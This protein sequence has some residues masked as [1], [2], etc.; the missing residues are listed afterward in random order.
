MKEIFKPTKE[1]LAAITAPLEPA[2]VLAGAGTGKTSVMAQRVLWLITEAKIEPSEI[3]GLTFTNKASQELRSRIRTTITKL[4]SNKL[5]VI[6]PNVSTYHS[7]AL[8]ILNEYGLILGI[9]SDLKPVTETTRAS[10]A[11]RTV[12]NTKLKLMALDKIPRNIAKQVLLLENQM[13]EHDLSKETIIEHSQNLIQQVNSVSAKS[14][15]KDLVKAAQERIELVQLVEEFRL[16]KESELVI[17]FADQ[18]RFCLQLVREFPQVK[19]EIRNQYKAVLLDEYQD[20]SVIQRMILAEVFG[21]GHPVTAVGDPLQAIYGWRGAS[22]S[23]IDNFTKHFE[24]SETLSASKYLLTENYRSGQN[25]LDQANNIS[26]D[27]RGIHH[28]INSLRAGKEIESNVN[29]GLYL[30]W[31]EEVKAIAAQITSLVFD[32]SEM[33]ENIA[34]LSRNGKELLAIYDALVK[35][36]VPASFAGKRDLMDVP[37]VSEVLA[38]LKL[39]DDP[40][41]NPAMVRILAGPRL[42]IDPRDLALLAKRAQDLISIQM[43]SRDKSFEKSLERAV[44]GNDVAELAVLADAVSSPGDYQYGQGVRERL[45]KFDRELNNLRN[46]ITE[47][48]SDVIYRILNTTGLLVEILSSNNLMSQSRYE[49]LMTL[50]ELAENFDQGSPHGALRE[51]LAWLEQAEELES[52]IEFRQVSVSNSVVLMTIHSAK[53]LEFPVVFIPALANSVFPSAKSSTWLTKAELIP[54]SLRADASSL[55]GNFALPKKEF[56]SYKEDCKK[57]AE[58]E[59]R[60]LMYV[61]LTRAEKELYVSG[62]HWGVMQKKSRGPSP[63]LLQIKESTKNIKIINWAENNEEKNPSLLNKEAYSWPA[64]TDEL[65]REQKLYVAQLIKDRDFGD[66][67]NITVEEKELLDN[68]DRDLKSLL[69]ELTN[70]KIKKRSVAVPD[71]LNVTKTINLMRDPNKF[72]LQLVRPMPTKPFTQARRGTQFHYWIENHFQMPTLL[73]ALDLPGSADED[74]I[75]DDQ[76]EQMKAAFLKSDW[77]N[78]KPLAIEWPFDISIQGRSL[79]GRIDAVFETANGVE[80]V[81]W[82]TGQVGKSDDLQLAWYRYAWWKMMKTPLKNIATAFVYIPGME[83]FRPDSLIEPELLLQ[84]VSKGA[85]PQ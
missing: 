2:L 75:T 37:E 57:Y 66:V 1:Q 73:D 31:E 12:L 29:L 84:S 14:H 20:T 80:L 34:V 7:F 78:K 19:A 11:Y 17:D 16:L 45:A 10:L 56:E 30:T 41:D 44:E 60:R 68:W 13:V 76:L 51:F 49:A 69:E 36:G 47:P 5:E 79:R 59:E 70:E 64:N 74:L 50:Q 23:N 4:F 32:K 8:Q 83:T 38:Y 15:L 26:A 21:Q 54:Y 55:P 65:T 27:L 81:D 33:P 48:L 22:V 72:A 53:G 42:E 18:M 28:D 82:K 24:K 35:N 71:T 77:A 39:M 63:Y 3:L 85:T 6:E 58:L 46:F 25:I 61:A 9:D 52:P 62:H 67:T 43:D 40:T